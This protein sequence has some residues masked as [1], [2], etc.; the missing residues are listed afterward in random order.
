MSPTIR[1]DS[2]AVNGASAARDGAPISPWRR[3]L[4]GRLS[5]AYDRLAAG[6]LRHWLALLNLAL[7]LFLALAF[8]APV[9]MALGLS[10]PATGIYAAYHLVCH[11][12]AFRSFFLFGPNAVYP[13][14]SLRGLVGEQRTFDFV[15]SRELGYKVAFCQRDV[16]IYAALLAGGLAF[17]RL[18]DRLRPIPLSLLGVLVLP[19]ALDGFTQLFGWRES[20]WQLRLATGALFGLAAAWLILPQLELS[21]RRAARRY[22][23]S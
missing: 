17:V 10:A 9:L 1:P 19:I 5:G 16:A 14:D 7:A 13:L 23:L 20:T 3:A 2:P 15:G 11:Q 18:R 22:G 8:I 12:W 21:A 4:D 6:T